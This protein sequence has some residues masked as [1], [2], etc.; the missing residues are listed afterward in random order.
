[1]AVQALAIITFPRRKCD[2]CAI[3]AEPDRWAFAASP[4]SRPPS[5]RSAA[6]VFI[7]S[8]GVSTRWAP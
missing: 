4:G 1:M 8:A 2:S 3:N 6:P 7:R 5:V